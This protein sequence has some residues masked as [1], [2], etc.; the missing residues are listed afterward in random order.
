[1]SGTGSNQNNPAVSTK[2]GADSVSYMFEVAKVIPEFFYEYIDKGLILNAPYNFQIVPM[3]YDHMAHI[4][5]L[6]F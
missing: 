4:E 1:L 3:E 6:F 2:L 5:L